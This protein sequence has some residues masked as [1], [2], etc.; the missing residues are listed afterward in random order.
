MEE[1]FNSRCKE[2]G[3]LAACWQGQEKCSSG[4]FPGHISSCGEKP[5]CPQIP[6]KGGGFL[7]EME[8]CC[9]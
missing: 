3:G 8:T 1:M 5:Q 9:L 2:V 6:G 7:G 4:L